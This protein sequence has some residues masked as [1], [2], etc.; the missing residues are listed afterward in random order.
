M[1]IKDI[2]WSPV[3]RALFIL[4]PAE[5]ISCACTAACL[6][7]VSVSSIF[8]IIFCVLLVIFAV[9]FGILAWKSADD[10]FM[11]YS[12]IVG[13]VLMPIAALSCVL[14]CGAVVKYSNDKAKTPF[15]MAIG[16]AIMINFTINIIQIINCCKWANIKDRLL[17][18]NNQVLFLIILNIVTGLFLGLIFGLIQIADSDEDNKPMTIVTV[19]FLFIGFLFGG[20]FALYNEWQTQK[21]QRIGL[22]PAAPSLTTEYDKM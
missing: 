21:M 7:G 14:V 8:A 17:T 9:V 11:R 15:Y 12:A 1:S 13:A 22:D 2:D 5:A 20:L 3:L 18:N 16:A 10:T 4:G 19:C 6:L